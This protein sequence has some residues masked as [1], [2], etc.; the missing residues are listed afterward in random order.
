MSRRRKREGPTEVRRRIAATAASAAIAVGGPAIAAKP[1][2]ASRGKPVTSPL[3]GILDLHAAR[4]DGS[5]TVDAVRRGEL[6]AH[7]HLLASALASELGTTRSGAIE[8]GLGQ[9]DAE[10]STAYAR[11]DRPELDGGLPRALGRRIGVT[12]DEVADAF[13]AMARHALERRL[14]GPSR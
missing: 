12:E 6:A 3:A 10:L 8:A 9:I 5:R 2:V 14:G 11:G 1:A 13:E 4:G 7:R